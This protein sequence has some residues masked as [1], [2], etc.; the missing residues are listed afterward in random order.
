[1]TIDEAKQYVYAKARKNQVGNIKLT[2]LN[3]FFKRAQDEVVNA[4]WG[5]VQEYQPGRPIPKK[6]FEITS[7]ISDDLAP[8]VTTTTLYN[9]ISGVANKPSDFL[10]YINLEAD[11]FVNNPDLPGYQSW[12]QVDEITHIEKPLRLN[13]QINYPK[14]EFP[15]AV[16]YGTYFKVYPENTQRVQIT[17]IRK[18]L[19]PYWAYTTI[20]G[21]PVYNAGGSQDF[22]LGAGVH[23]MICEKVLE[24]FGVSTRDEELFQISQT[25]QA[26]GS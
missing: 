21:Q 10:Y 26:Q 12:V 22:E 1:M 20:N 5:Q 23:N 14:A 2:D 15:V 16:N 17:Y 4:L 25:K 3:V 8:L 13:S 19:T 6:A 24:Y 18:P 9:L 7:T 11:Y